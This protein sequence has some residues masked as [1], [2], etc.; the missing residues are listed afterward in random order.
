MDASANSSHS[1]RDKRIKS[2]IIFSRDLQKQLPS[3]NDGQVPCNQVDK[4]REQI[5]AI[6]SYS[7]KSPG[8]HRHAQ[9]DSAGTDLWNWCVKV[10]REDGEETSPARRAF[11]TF[12]RVF[13]FLILALAQWGDHNAPGDL[14][15]LEKLAIKTGRSCIADGE[16]KFAFMALQ[17]AA[18]YHGLLQSMQAKL[19]VEE[20]AT[21][22]NL[23]VEC[24]TLRIV[25]KAWKEDRLDVADHLYEKVQDCNRTTNPAS[26]ENF[27]DSLF[28]I[29]N[30]LVTKKNFSLAVKWLKRAYEFINSQDLDQLSREVVE[31]RLTISQALI[32]AYLN[33]N[34]A[35][36]F[37]SAENHVCWLESELGDKLVVLLLRLELLLS[38]P[39]EVFDSNAYATILRRMIGSLE[40]SESSF[41]VMIHHIR[42]LDDK[43]PS[44]ASSILS[45][46]ITLR[47]LLTQH[48]T[49]IERAI[50]LCVKMATAR[51]DTY[52]TI[53]ELRTIFDNIAAKLETSLS[54]AAVLAIQV[55]I[56]KKVDAAFNEGA[57]DITEKWCHVAIHPA[58]RHS[59]PANTAKI[60]RKLMCCA[61]QRNSLDNATKVFQSMSESTRREPMTLYLAYKLALRSRD[62][63]MASNCLRHIIEASPKDPQYLYACCI[64]AQEANDKVCAIEALKH[65]IQNSE[66]N[67]TDAVHLPALLRV[68]IRLEISLLNDRE[69]NDAGRSLIID[70][71]CQVFEG[72]VPAIQRDPRN[73][74]G[75]KIFTVEELD[76]FGKNAYNL[77]VKM[78]NTGQPRQSIRIFQCCLSIIS[79]Y[80]N[81]IPTQ[82]AEDLSL[83]TMFCHFLMATM[84]I[85]LAR[86]QDNI[87]MQLQDY[88]LMRSHVNAFDKELEVRLNTLDEVSKNDLQMKLSTLLVFDFE[89]AI[90]LK[91]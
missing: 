38:S 31:L 68:V 10:K 83:R 57:L 64:D 67:S 1:A 62:Q 41:N 82:A 55:L 2:I 84:Q 15:R 79:Q 20:L 32:R 89:G 88:L 33:L 19:P 47:I 34:T 90:C 5:N 80:P 58:L 52:E 49:W 74:N 71:I 8:S 69:E 85:A 50:V 53:Q 86:A 3:K 91:S 13:S 43:S 14:L 21:C 78:V 39:A 6:K 46:F 26:A 75:D 42:K 54:A 72:V 73:G 48:S 56:W 24:L 27:A 87:E 66:Y 63:E 28:E 9:L 60:T 11:L 45:E 81:D 25:L 29:G 51:R 61:L 65:L 44:L 17:K 12:A 7:L 4:L 76:W 40:I 59:G 35:E 30:D 77:A 18:E 23:E 16:L 36:S 22:R 70:D 37:K